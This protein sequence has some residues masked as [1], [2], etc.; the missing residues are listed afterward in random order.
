MPKVVIREDK[1]GRL[2]LWF[3]QSGKP[4]I[5]L[6]PFLSGYWLGQYLESQAGQGGCQGMH[7]AFHTEQLPPL[8]AANQ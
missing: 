2:S 4:V 5:Q 1:K 8:P 3:C 7:D 6:Y